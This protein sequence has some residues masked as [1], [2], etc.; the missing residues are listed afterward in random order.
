MWSMSHKVTR[1][2]LIEKKRMKL[3]VAKLQINSTIHLEQT[4]L[5]LSYFNRQEVLSRTMPS[6]DEQAVPWV[7]FEQ[8]V[9][10]AEV[11]VVGD[12]F[13]EHD[14]SISFKSENEN[15]N[16]SLHKYTSIQRMILFLS[17]LNQQIRLISSMSE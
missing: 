14:E 9:D 8:E 2:A 15:L 12:G 17:A 13:R 6:I 16:F 4:H 10:L 1:M 7:W 5:S 11:R 3:K